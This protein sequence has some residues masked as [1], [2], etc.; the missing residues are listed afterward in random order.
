[1][2]CTP[3]VPPTSQIPRMKGAAY[4]AVMRD[5]LGVT[6]VAGDPP[7]K[8][9]APDYDGSMTAI[10]W[11][12]YLKT[13]EKIAADVIAGSNRSQFM[14]C[15]PAVGTCLTDTIKSF[16]RKAFRRPL[17]P[18][19]V[20]SFER[21]KNVTPV[22]TPAEIAETILFAFLAS[23]SF[24]MLPE[25]SADK[26]LDGTANQLTSFEAAARLSF[27]L[28][29]TVPD[30]ELNAAADN[31]QLTSKEQI[32]EQARRM[33]KSDKVEPAVARFHQAYLG[34]ET[35]SHWLNNKEHDP[36]FTKYT[37]ATYAPLLGEMD[38]FFKE[39]VFKGGTLND[40]F[41]S[42]VAFV[43][44]DTAAVYGLDPAAYG[45]EPVRVE[46]DPKQRPGFLT[47]AG[48][49]STFS[50]YGA[51]SPILRGAFISGRILGVHPGEPTADALKTPIPPGMYT[52]R[53]QQ[54]E[55]LTGVPACKS[56]HA[57]FINPAGFVLERYDAIGSWQDTDQLTGPIDGTA[58]VFL[59]PGQ[60]KT[61]SSPLDMMK[62]LAAQA[63]VQRHYA[64][65][66]V[67]FATGRAPNEN[68]ACTVN[69]LATNLARANYPVLNL[70]ADYTEADSFRLRTVGP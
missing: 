46:L 63:T 29:G 42:N 60:K 39:L 68:D 49:L 37:A 57:L 31:D 4:N 16:G 1:G 52:T 33:L 48:F 69:Q 65:Q 66:F 15:E 34:I 2:S 61:I 47:R 67:T 12:G 62:E 54:I 19:E 43:T 50:N 26:S 58:D 59:G 30:D 9:L 21:F 3:G 10:A 32:A 7:S 44:R 64:E 28:W 55:A 56:C 18:A 35:S 51:T 24:I 13:A 36:K 38:S 45:A 17:T 11:D 70:M 20:T 41:L 22:G 40:L 25:L 5:L 27:L 23:P 8:A 14:A 53:R 6:A